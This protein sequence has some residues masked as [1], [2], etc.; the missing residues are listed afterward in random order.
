MTWMKCEDVDEEGRFLLRLVRN[1]G[2]SGD[3]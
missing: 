1:S 2:E 3:F